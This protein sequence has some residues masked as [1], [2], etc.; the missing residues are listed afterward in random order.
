[1]ERE[2]TPSAGGAAFHQGV[3][4]A[5]MEFVAAWRGGRADSNVVVEETLQNIASVKAFTDEDYEERR[6][7]SSLDAFLAVILR[8]ARYEGGFISFIVFALF[9]AIVLVVW[10]G[11]RLVVAGVL[12]PGE[13]TYFMLYTLYVSGAVGSFAALYGQIQRTLGAT[14]RV[15]E[16]LQEPPEPAE[17]GAR[18]RLGCAATWCSRTCRSATRRARRWRCC[19]G[20]R[21]RRGRD[22]ASP[23]SAA[24]RRAS[25]PW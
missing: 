23:W 15:R 9:G 8:T 5:T 18:A 4:H 21:C 17:S 10:Y 1:M 11:A 3:S 20:F 14:Q 16:L 24:A 13:L 2:A 19:A 6:Y 25:Q 12:S 7:R 22:S